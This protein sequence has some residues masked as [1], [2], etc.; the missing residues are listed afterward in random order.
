[1][2]NET[3]FMLVVVS[4]LLIIFIAPHVCLSC[5]CN[6][7]SYTDTIKYEPLYDT[8]CTIFRSRDSVSGVDPLTDYK[9]RTAPN[10][11]KYNFESLIYDNTRESI[12][13]G[14]QFMEDTGIVAPLWIPPAWDP[15]VMGPSSKGELVPGDFENDPRMLYNKCSLSCCGAQYPLPFKIDDDKFAFDKNG[16]RKFL[17]SDYTCTNNTGGTGCLCLSPKQASGF[18]KGF[19]DYYVDRKLGY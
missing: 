13:T 4:L 10:G 9:Q 2:K 14:T 6:R 17:T 19:V 18:R 5:K 7:E 8:N 3:V 1:M 16:K 12:M 11:E 15:N